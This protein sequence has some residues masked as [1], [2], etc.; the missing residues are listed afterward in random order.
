MKQKKRDPRYPNSEDQLTHTGHYSNI[1]DDWNIHS[2]GTKKLSIP[3]QRVFDLLLT[4]RYTAREIT[5]R[6]GYFD[7]RNIIRRLKK[8][9]I[10]VEERWYKRVQTGERFKRFAIIPPRAEQPERTNDSDG[11]KS[12]REILDQHFAY[13]NR[14]NKDGRD[15]TQ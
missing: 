2:K 6:T 15:N 5:I 7:P 3:Q 4:G 10:Q 13:L 14:G 9:G 12:I 8:K 1:R 11:P